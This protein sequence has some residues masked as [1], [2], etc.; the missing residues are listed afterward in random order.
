M[1]RFTVLLR[2]LSVE[3]AHKEH[4]N[5]QVGQVPPAPDAKTPRLP[6]ILRN[7][8]VGLLELLAIDISSYYMRHK[9]PVDTSLSTAP[10]T[11]LAHTWLFY[12]MVRWGIDAA[13][14]LSASLNIALHIF[15]P[16]DFP[17]LFGS[18]GNA[19]TMKRFWGITWHQ[20]MRTVAEPYTNALVR[21]SNLDSRRKSTYWVKVASAF[22]WAGAMHAY[23]AL[24][25]GGS[26]WSDVCQFG[27]QILAFW[28]E[29]VV[30]GLAK[31]T[32]IRD[33]WW[34]RGV[35]YV[36]VF[37]FQGATLWW[38]PSPAEVGLYAKHPLSVVEWVL[39]GR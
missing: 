10:L 38:Y 33:G 13:Y 5:F 37:V 17:P 15:R 4:R 3:N 23:G 6:Y 27:S 16:S 11:F 29:D 14:R 19:Y 7:L 26:V 25:A 28:V 35:G 31:K 30:I 34:V 24:I 32:G 39:E 8:S 21:L 36:W 9:T 12:L 22:F 18:L 1:H 2:C 20:M